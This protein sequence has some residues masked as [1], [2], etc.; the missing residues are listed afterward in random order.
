MF[1]NLYPV[2]MSSSQMRKFSSVSK[3]FFFF[4]AF[5]SF[6]LAPAFAKAD[7]CGYVVKLESA[8]YANGKTTFVW[9]V[10]NP[11]PGNG[12]NGTYQDLSHFGVVLGSCVDL[13]DIVS[14]G[15]YGKDP[16]QN[17]YTSPYLKFDYG[18]N[19]TQKAT[20]TLVLNGKYGVAPTTAVFKSGVR[21]GCCTTTIQGVGCKQTPCTP[22]CEIKGGPICK[23]G[24]NAASTVL[25]GPNGVGY[26]YSWT[27]PNGFSATTQQ[28]TVTSETGTATVGGPGLYTLTVKTAD[29]CI[30]TCTKEITVV[31]KPSCTISGNPVICTDGSNMGTTVLKGSD[32]VGYT[33]SWTGPNGFTAITQQITVNSVGN[34]TPGPG[35]YTLTV[36]ANGCSST[37]TNTV[38]VSVYPN[39]TLSTPSKRT[40][41]GA[42]LTENSASDFKGNLAVSTMPNPFRDKVRFV[43][44]S[45]VSG[46]AVL[47]IFNMA[48]EKLKT[49]YQGYIQAGREQVVEYTTTGAPR[50]NLVYR[51]QVGSDQVSGKLISAH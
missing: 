10:Y 5:P 18:T 3:I 17:C 33:Y 12:T 40:G 48:G 4:F 19:G 42:V 1:T 16:S 39:C 38:A 29:G 15:S 44:R 13:K 46:Q 28:I 32:G 51:L 31:Q 41:S 26:T 21:T 6:L 24:S 34:G 30:S 43:I 25:S 11:K 9:S 8:T 36:T 2:R 20:Y 50:A 49:V 45:K 47:E 7:G 22:S 23:D 14:G 27:G 35:L 37:C